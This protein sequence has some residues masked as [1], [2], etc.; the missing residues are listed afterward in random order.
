MTGE[1]EGKLL[2][3]ALRPLCVEIMNNLSVESL[4]SLQARLEELSSPL[5][6][7]LVPYI[8]IPLRAA[9]KR[10]GRQELADVSYVPVDYILSLPAPTSVS[11]STL[12]SPWLLCSRV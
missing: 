1:T 4:T 10:T 2:F 3:Q 5:P 6:T 9:I 8:T 7:P 12:S 11:W